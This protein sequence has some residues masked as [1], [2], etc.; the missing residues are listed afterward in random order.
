APLPDPQ[1]MAPAGLCP[2][3]LAAV[4][5]VAG[6]AAYE[7]RDESGSVVSTASSPMLSPG[8][9]E[10]EVTDANGCQ[11]N[12][13]FFIESYEQPPLTLSTPDDTGYCPP[14]ETPPTLHA[15]ESDDGYTY[16]WY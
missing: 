15:T 10:V 14:V 16:Q 11:G 12:T 1:V 3:D 5:T 8:H 6:Y 2:G 4:S 13:T 7:W 9:Y